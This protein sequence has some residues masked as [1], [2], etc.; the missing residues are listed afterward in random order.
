MMHRFLH[1][2][3]HNFISKGVGMSRMRGLRTV[4][5]SAPWEF[6]HQLLQ[7]RCLVMPAHL[8]ECQVRLQQ[9]GGSSSLLIYVCTCIHAGCVK[10]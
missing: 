5:S 3:N 2:P 9:A 6:L 7:L 8:L 1:L 4:V 10:V